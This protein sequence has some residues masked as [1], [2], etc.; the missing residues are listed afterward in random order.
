MARAAR[1]LRVH[2]LSAMTAAILVSG[3]PAPLTGAD[4]TA[5]DHVGSGPRERQIRID[6][7]VPDP[8][9]GSAYRLVYAVPVAIDVYWAFKTD[10][11][12]DWLEQNKYILE[13]RFASRSGDIVIT[14]DKYANGPGV[15]FRWETRLN[16]ADHRLDFVLLN[17]EQCHQKFHYG[18]IQL[19]TV[20]E[21]T[22]VTQVAFFDFLGASVWAAYPWAGGMRE[23]LFYTAKWEQDMVLRLKDR[24]SGKGVRRSAGQLK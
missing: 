23:F 11:D 18:H 3:I 19:E 9:G 2:L 8:R 14:E 12:N 10:F 4:A 24:Y 17:P 7:L 13:H 16:A 21:G 1:R 5:G 20:A 6:R 15:F 22:R